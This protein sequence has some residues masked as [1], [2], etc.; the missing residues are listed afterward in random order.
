ML[1]SRTA[2][3]LYWVSRY[4]ERAEHCAR[5]LSVRLDLGLDRRPGVD[6]WDFQRAYESLRMSPSGQMPATPAGLVAS[7]FLD[8]SNPESVSSY[9]S[10]ARGNARQVREEISADMW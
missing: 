7:V 2:D 5:L 9:V 3:A 4:L 8:A 1:L 10:A 6:Q